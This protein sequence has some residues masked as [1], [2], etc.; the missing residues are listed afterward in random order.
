[1]RRAGWRSDEE[2]DFI[3][4]DWLEEDDDDLDDFDIIDETEEEEIPL[5][6]D[7]PEHAPLGYFS[8][9]LQA[10]L[11][12]IFFLIYSVSVSPEYKVLKRNTYKRII[13]VNS[14]LKDSYYW[15]KSYFYHFLSV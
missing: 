5:N 10:Y 3:E 1:M 9:Y 15:W 4:E 14:S 7:Y 13:R 12:F 2:D 11:D 6:L 8:S